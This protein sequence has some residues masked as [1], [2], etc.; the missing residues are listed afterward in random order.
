MK[1]LRENAKARY[2]AD[3]IFASTTSFWKLLSAA[4]FWEGSNTFPGVFNAKLEGL[5]HDPLKDGLPFNKHIQMWLNITRAQ[6]RQ[7]RTLEL[8][9]QM[10]YFTVRYCR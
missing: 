4:Y 10:Y 5:V 9:Q 1:E 8:I 2:G 7:L 6:L 3:N